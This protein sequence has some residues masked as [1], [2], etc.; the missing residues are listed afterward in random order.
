MSDA[1][2]PLPAFPPS[3]SDEAD[4]RRQL[5]MRQLQMLGELAEIGLEIAGAVE[6]AAAGKAPAPAL[7]GD[8][9]LAYA[10]VTRSVRQ[11]ILLQSQLIEGLN[12]EDDGADSEGAEAADDAAEVDHRK[13]RVQRI[14]ERVAKATYGDDEDLVERD[15]LEAAEYLDDEDL[16]GDLMDRPV[17]EL[18]ARICRDLGLEPRW[19]DLVQELWAQK[20]LDTG[21]PGEP[22]RALMGEASSPARGRGGV[23]SDGDGI[24]PPPS[25]EPPA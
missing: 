10:R 21:A 13:A 17:S 8:A 15:T 22:L 3:A 7:R 2:P 24:P 11:T 4:W 6:R 20:E 9:A 5:V 14:V 18:V 19:A 12:G 1:A 16:Y 23:R 25:C